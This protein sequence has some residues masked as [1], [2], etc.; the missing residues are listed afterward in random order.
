[1]DL[2]AIGMAINGLLAA[3][4]NR[5]NAGSALGTPVTLSFS[6]SGAGLPFSAPQREAVRAILASAAQ[7]SGLAFRETAEAGAD[8]RF[9]ASQQAATK[10]ISS[11]PGE[12]GAGQVS[13]DSETLANLA[14]GSE[15]YAALL[16]EIGHALGLRHPRNVQTG[17]AYAYQWPAAYDLTSLSVMAQ[18]AAPDG[19]FPAA[20]GALDLVALR[21]LYGSRPLNSLDTHYTLDA[22]RFAAQSAIT[23]DGGSDTIDAALAPSGVTLDLAPGS[24]SSVGAGALGN[25]MIAPG[26][27]IENAAGSAFDDVLLGNARDNLLTGAK[28]NDWIDGGAGRDSALFAGARSDYLFSAAFGKLFVAARDGSGGFDT[29]TGIETLVFADATVT[30]G[31]ALGA[32]IAI[33]VDQNAS[34]AGSLSASA[35]ASFALARAAA[36]GSV[37]LSA[38]GDYLYTPAPGYSSED[39]FSY[40]LADGAGGSNVFSVFITVR[41]ASPTIRGGAGADRLAGSAA[42]DIIDAGAGDDRIAGSLGSDAVEGGAGLDTLSYAAARGGFVFAPA[43]GAKVTVAKPGGGADTLGGVERIAF[44][45]S[46]LAFDVDGSAGQAWRLYQAAFGRQP[47]AAGLGYWI[48]AFDGGAARQHVAAGFMQS[49]EFLGLYGA[50]ASAEQFVG[51]LYQHVLQ[52]APDQAGLAYWLDAIGA[53]YARSMVLADFADSAENRAQLIGAM[54]AGMEFTPY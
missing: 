23:D 43:G 42:N 21:H 24:L 49:A 29:L 2:D 33:E 37:T 19:R 12:P 38:S 44:T 35:A 13:M 53:G 47:D 1:M 11:M 18:A 14:P 6:F 36:H 30:P 9:G 15:G 17:D 48:A 16:H 8:L 52:R 5:W 20:W 31:G 4:A 54:Q 39:S 41:P 46:A 40:T 10:G 26:S 3:D 25:L 32:D 45:D 7:A 28:G 34:V 22:L 27:W 51:K 50:A